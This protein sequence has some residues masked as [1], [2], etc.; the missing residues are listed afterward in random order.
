MFKTFQFFKHVY[1]LVLGFVNIPFDQLED[2]MGK[3]LL[4]VPDPSET[5][6]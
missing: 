6:K 1:I 4:N 2:I 3:L 5:N